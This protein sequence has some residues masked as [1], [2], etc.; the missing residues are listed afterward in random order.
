[1]GSGGLDAVVNHKKMVNQIRY[2][3]YK[4]LIFE[5]N[6]FENMGH[7]GGK[8][9]TFTCGLQFV[10]KRR[11]FK[12]NEEDLKQYVG[13]YSSKQFNATIRAEKGHLLIII[14]IETG[15]KKFTIYPMSKNEFSIEESYAEFKFIKNKEGKVKG[16]KV[17]TNKDHFVNLNKDK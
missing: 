13:E 1:M 14:D 12:L 7:A 11:G 10:Y 16:F 6:I 8:I 3:N 2:R 17:E 15:T 4:N 5:D 9:Q